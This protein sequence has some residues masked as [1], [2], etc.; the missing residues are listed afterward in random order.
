MAGAKLCIGLTGRMASGK[1]EA[2]RILNG[3][4]FRYISLSD[5]VRS[6]AAKVEPRVNRSQMQDIGN[7]LRQ[8]GGAGI[9]GKKVR[10]LVAVADEKRWVIDGI[11]N[12]AEVLELKKIGDFFLI[13]IE[14]AMQNIVARLKKRGRVT[15]M[16][17][18]KELW[19]SLEREWGNGEP[20]GGQQVGRCLAIADFT[21]ANNG[22]LAELKT[23]LDEVLSKIGAGHA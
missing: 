18:E 16:A 20:A 23:R 11:R 10:E 12:P 6:E 1:G 14:S 3:Y 7:R 9:L 19:A 4:G 13:A 15:D 22:T 21:V 5:I 8:E 2:V 17:A